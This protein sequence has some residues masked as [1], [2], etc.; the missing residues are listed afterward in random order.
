ME[1]TSLDN[2]CIITSCVWCTNTILVLVHH[3]TTA[4]QTYK[5]IF[6]WFVSISPALLVAFLVV[7]AC[8]RALTHAWSVVRIVSS[9]NAITNIWK[10]H[11]YL[12]SLLLV[13]ICQKSQF[14]S[15]VFNAPL[16]EIVNYCANKK[17]EFEYIY[18]SNLLIFKKLQ[19]SLNNGRKRIE[20]KLPYLW[21]TPVISHIH[22]SR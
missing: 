16:Y 6:D 7:C 15:T 10:L 9:V 14:L 5:S 12:C 13:Y 1:T 3:A 22:F 18:F 4:P 17:F 20:T 11:M 21:W 8:R 2:H 19:F